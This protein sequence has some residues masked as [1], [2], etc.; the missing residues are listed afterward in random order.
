[1]QM[2]SIRMGYCIDSNMSFGPPVSLKYACNDTYM[3]EEYWM[4]FACQGKSQGA[5]PFWRRGC[6]P[7]AN[8]SQLGL[9]VE[10]NGKA[11]PTGAPAQEGVHSDGPLPSS[12]F[13]AANSAALEAINK[14]LLELAA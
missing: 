5:L 14:F 9:L 3:E 12:P 1:M 2:A 7:A 6:T 11:V 10:C 13:A 4:G 8:S